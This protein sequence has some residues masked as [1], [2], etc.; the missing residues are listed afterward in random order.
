MTFRQGSSDTWR[1][2]I[3]WPP[4]W[5][6]MSFHVVMFSISPSPSF[7]RDDFDFLDHNSNYTI[8]LDWRLCKTVI[9]AWIYTV[10]LFFLCPRHDNILNLCMFIQLYRWW[11]QAPSVPLG[12]VSTTGRK[13]VLYRGMPYRAD[14]EERK[15]L[16]WNSGLFLEEM[17]SRMLRLK[18]PR[19]RIRKWQLQ[20]NDAIGDQRDTRHP[21]YC[22]IKSVIQYMLLAW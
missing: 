20:S 12:D 1:P 15:T 19:R 13:Q 8:W 4:I 22:G 9:H 7:T 3:I 5:I 18:S 21:K 17:C 14:G 16:S 2:S 10:W 6:Y 11:R